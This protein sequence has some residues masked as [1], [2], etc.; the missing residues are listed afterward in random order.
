MIDRER[1][2]RAVVA[3][4]QRAP[5]C[6]IDRPEACG[7]QGQ[8]QGIGNDPGMIQPRR[9]DRV[10]PA[11]HRIVRHHA[12]QMPLRRKLRAKRQMDRAQGLG[13]PVL[14][15]KGS[16]SAR[17]RRP[18]S[19]RWVE[20][21]STRS[22]GTNIMAGPTSNRSISR[23]F[24]ASSDQIPAAFRPSAAAASAGCGGNDLGMGCA[25]SKADGPESK[26]A[27]HTS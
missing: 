13:D 8:C 4:D 11:A 23:I 19:G 14:D 25:Y 3:P 9:A 10:E 2:P 1:K 21:S 15:A 5:T 6:Q 16:A 17:R 7:G 18:G 20:S 22:V 27:A 24:P 12:R 26:R